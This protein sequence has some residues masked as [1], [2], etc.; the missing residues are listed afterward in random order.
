[1]Q[2]VIRH[3]Q[4]AVLI[5]PSFGAGWYSWNTAHPELL[6]H[7]KIVWMVERNRSKLI[8]SA[9]VEEN[10]GMKDVYCGGAKGLEIH[11]LPVGTRFEVKEQGG[12]ES[13]VTLTN[14]VLVA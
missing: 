8:D 5:S 1:M 10:L 2:K 14:L 11:W 9:W 13:L 3:N 12:S 6:Y 4:V 7:P